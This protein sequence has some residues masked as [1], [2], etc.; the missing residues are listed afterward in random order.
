MREIRMPEP[1]KNADL[2]VLGVALAAEAFG[3]AS[4]VD[5]P[6]CSI[7]SPATVATPFSTTVPG[8]PEF[9]EEALLLGRGSESDDLVESFIDVQIEY[10][11]IL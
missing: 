1:T 7:V 5:A 4:G 9:E 2:P 6:T 11:F 8:C 3:C 10:S